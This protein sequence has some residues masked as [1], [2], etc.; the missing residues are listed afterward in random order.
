MQIRSRLT[1]SYGVLLLF[2]AATL[3]VAVFRFDQVSREV[4]ALVNQDAAMAQQASVIN[5]N[6][7]SIASR[8]LLLFI[9]EDKEQRK[10]LYREMDSRNQEIDQAVARLKV[11]I[12]G[13][14]E[15]LS[16]LEQLRKVYQTRLQA[17]VERL[18]MGQRAEARRMMAGETRA[19]LDRLL[20]YTDTLAEQ[21]LASMQARQQQTLI[22]AERS[23]Y[24]LVL[25]GLGALALGVLM[26]LLITRSIVRPLNQA[27]L[28]A[29]RI[30]AGDLSA[31]V[32]PGRSD[33]LGILLSSM[34]AM[35][36]QLVEVIDRIRQNA[37]AVSQAADQ[38][39]IT[40]SGV[41]GI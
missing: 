31:Q 30:A 4:D 3:V 34:A 6:A 2:I 14:Q 28:A 39:V 38:R 32:P 16:R 21:Q 9:L 20:A 5:L 11:L 13:Q 24:T 37:T 40:R 15:V 8:L 33:E 17:T 27:V 36:E 22:T 18:E 12:P 41:Q 23:V 26:S 19:A 25:I 1:I 7:E 35:R 29:D 10:A